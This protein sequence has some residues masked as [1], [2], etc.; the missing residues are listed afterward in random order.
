MGEKPNYM[1]GKKAM[2][3]L[4]PEYVAALQSDNLKQTLN[5]A[6]IDEL[7]NEL[8]AL[9]EKDLSNND[10]I[11]QAKSI[12]DKYVTVAPTPEPT[13]E[14]VTQKSLTADSG[15]RGDWWDSLDNG[16]KVGILVGGVAVLIGIAYATSKL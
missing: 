8:E 13:P 5:K 3:L 4:P 7:S 9:M 10:F 1:I 12:I 6:K 14:D 2:D 15:S 16:K 11:T